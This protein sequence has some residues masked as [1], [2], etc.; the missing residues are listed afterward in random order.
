MSK[1]TIILGILLV[2]LGLLGYFVVADPDPDTGKISITA[3][4]PAFFGLPLLILGLIALSKGA[5][6]IAMHIAVVLGLFGLIG[7]LM[8]PAM[9]LF[10]GKSITLNKALT[11]QLSM[12]ALCLIFVI[13]CVMSFIKARRAPSG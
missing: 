2:L 9:N 8:R 10:G 11:M 5:R 4:I 12:A 3:M 7:A 13:L 1:V 6:A